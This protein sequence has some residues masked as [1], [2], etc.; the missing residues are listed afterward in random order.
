MLLPVDVLITEHKLILRAVELVNKEADKI[1]ANKSVNPNFI[2]TVVDFFR[3]YA[4]RFH[5]G[6]EEGI[7]FRELS[8][9]KLNQ[10]DLKV[11]NELLLEHTFARRTVTAL[12]QAKETYVSGRTEALKDVLELLSSLVK[13]YPEH[14]EK[15]DNH[16]FYPCMKYF[17]EQ[18]QQEMLD[19]FLGFNQDF[20]DKRYKQIINSLE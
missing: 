19:S 14:I 3:T 2:T 10:A 7:L 11:M 5:H 8:Q 15:E 18:E 12:E 13:L 17:S 4:D 20:T 9:K 16:Y 6:K 1:Q